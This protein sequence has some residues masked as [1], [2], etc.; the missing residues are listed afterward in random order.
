MTPTAKAPLL[1]ARHARAAASAPSGRDFDRPLDATGRFD[2]AEMGA[3]L[4]AEGWALGHLVLSPALRCRETAAALSAPQAPLSER[5]E[6]RFYSGGVEAYQ[7]VIEAAAPDASMTLIGH[8]PSVDQL[9]RLLL[10]E[11][12]AARHLPFGFPPGAVLCL[13]RQADG[14]VLF[15]AFLQP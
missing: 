1:I 12:E 9:A 5:E 13:D 14:S 11:A 6:P 8:N 3:R 7:A 4:V 10:G 15:L 2:A